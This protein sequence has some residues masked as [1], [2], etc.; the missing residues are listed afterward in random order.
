MHQG[1]QIIHTASKSPIVRVN[2]GTPPPLVNA[3]TYA[4]IDYL[5]SAMQMESL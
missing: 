1:Q 3:I 5:V 2:S 4:M